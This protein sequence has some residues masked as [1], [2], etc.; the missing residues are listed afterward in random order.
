MSTAPT[1]SAPAACWACNATLTSSALLC[2]NCGKVQPASGADYFQVFGLERK[3]AL[4]PA[5]LEREFHRLSRRLHP[6]RFARATAEEQQWSLANTALLNDAYRTLR[7]PIQR[8]EY[9]LPLEGLKIGE[10]HAGKGK[11]VDRQPPADLLEEVFDLNMQ[12]EEMRMNQKM[13]ENDPALQSDLTAA[14]TRFDALLT[15][16]DA[17]LTAK[18]AEWDAGDANTRDKAAKEMAALL[19]R[20]RYL[21]NLVRDVNE[22]LSTAAA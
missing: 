3:L 12:L 11:S 15:A 7:D 17:D 8:T 10:E 1:S 21:R 13:G 14:R 16:V 18:G 22:V 9:L 20:R 19:D 5:A 2:P 4:D 6:D